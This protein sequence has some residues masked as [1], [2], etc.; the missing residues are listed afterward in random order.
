V[1]DPTKLREDLARRRAEAALQPGSVRT[2]VN[3][4]LE[5]TRN[6]QR[7]S[8]RL[9][10]RSDD[11]LATADTRLALAL[12]AA[13]L[14]EWDLDLDT[15]LLARSQRLERLVG[16]LPVTGGPVERF[17]DH[18]ERVDAE[19]LGKRFSQ[20]EREWQEDFGFRGQ[21][22]TIWLS[23]R[24]RSIVD[25][26]GVPRR[27]IGV[28][29][30]ITERR[31]AESRLSAALAEKDL[32]LREKDF[33]IKEIHHR[34]KNNLQMVASL[35][36]IQARTITDGAARDLFD[37]ALSRV[38]VIARVHQRLY[39]DDQLSRVN[40]AKH[41]H[42]LV[43][44]LQAA[45]G[46]DDAP[47]ELALD[48]LEV[49]LDVAVPLSLALHEMLI[50]AMKYAYGGEP[51]WIGVKLRAPAPGNAS[52][53][54]EVR[55]RGSGFGDSAK[56]GLGLQLV[57]AFARQIGGT[58]QVRQAVQGARVSL[59]WRPFAGRDERAPSLFADT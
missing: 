56:H 51:G 17:V 9:V 16:N 22:G 32:L 38:R 49:A 55:D 21:A 2:R 57:R 12:S 20:G 8:T 13:R 37:Q 24:A 1:P 41:V 53:L 6:A 31:R 27:L 7:E 19:R 35:L 4:L 23:L 44:D 45:H 54:L 11:I 50:N 29:L 25:E 34:V 18:L 3:Q 39:T 14:G 52:A 42:D 43:R 48:P 30:D 40:L 33:L 10:R 59:S 58:M 26:H 5:R 36:S 47:V 46:W 15:M 28:V